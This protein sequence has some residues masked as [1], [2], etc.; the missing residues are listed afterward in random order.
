MSLGI[1]K[2]GKVVGKIVRAEFFIPI[3]A[4]MIGVGFVWI[5]IYD[6]TYGLLNSILGYFGISPK[7]WLRDPAWVMPAIILMSIWKSLG[8]TII[9]FLAGLRAIPARYYEAAAIDGAKRVQ[10]FRS[11]TLPLLTPTALFVL[12]TT[13]IGAF[14]VFTQVFVMTSSTGIPPGGPAHASIVV[15]VRIY[16]TAFTFYK[17]GLASAMAIVLFIIIFVLSLLEL[18]YIPQREIY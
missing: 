1:N 12:V 13:I 3:V 9:L 16:E 11:I 7:S 4:S 6:P 15:V 8:Y 17:M 5:W 10:V 2:L 14:Q 18:K